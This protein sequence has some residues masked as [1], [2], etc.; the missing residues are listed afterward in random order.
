M[1]QDHF[2]LES[3]VIVFAVFLTSVKVIW[4]KTG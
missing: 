1:L 2:S 3:P 4:Q